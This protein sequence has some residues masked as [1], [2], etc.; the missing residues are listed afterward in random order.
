MFYSCNMEEEEEEDVIKVD[1]VRQKVEEIERKG[2]KVDRD[3]VKRIA[4]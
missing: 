1:S 2:G 4:A 3:M